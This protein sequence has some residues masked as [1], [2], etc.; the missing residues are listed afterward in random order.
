[1]VIETERLILRPVTE[2]DDREIFEYSKEP[3]VGVNAGWKPHE[4]IDESRE[5]MKY[6][7]LGVDGAFA[8]VLKSENKIIGTIGLMPDA[9]RENDKARTIGYSISEK[10][11]GR[12]LMT[13]AVRAVVC[14]AFDKA[15]AELVSAYCYPNNERSKRVLIKNGFTYEGRLSR[16]EVLYDG[17]VLDNECYVLIK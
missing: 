6:V 17:R 10:Y 8:I 12:G 4:T 11:W 2:S 3:N 9:K 14:F 16:C 1:M 15:G 13:E 5:F 7:L